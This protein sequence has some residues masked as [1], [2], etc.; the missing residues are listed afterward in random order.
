MRNYGVSI[1]KCKAKPEYS[2]L[3]NSDNFLA[4]GSASTHLWLEAGMEVE[5]SKSLLPLNKKIKDCLT[6]IKAKEVK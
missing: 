6:E 4:L 1:M 3:S 5:I 2:K